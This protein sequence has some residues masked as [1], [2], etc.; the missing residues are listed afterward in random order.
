VIYCPLCG[1]PPIIPRAAPGLPPEGHGCGCHHLVYCDGH[2][3]FGG[4]G[5]GTVMMGG[6]RV[7]R[8]HRDGA[9]SYVPDEMVEEE[10]GRMVDDV[11]V[12]RVLRS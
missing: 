4:W 12:L 5:L 6:N 10:V 2:L 11:T 1:T 8:V 3:N 9:M 7:M